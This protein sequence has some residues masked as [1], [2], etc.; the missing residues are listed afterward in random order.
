[1]DTFVAEHADVLERVRGLQRRAAAPV[2]PS[3]LAVIT[4]RLRS[5]CA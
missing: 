1:V 3:A 2:S 5:L 4:E